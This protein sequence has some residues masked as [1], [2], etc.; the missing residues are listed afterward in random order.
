MTQNEDKKPQDETVLDDLEQILEDS[1]GNQYV[2]QF[3][4]GVLSKAQYGNSVKTQAVYLSQY[5]LIPYDRVRDHFTDQLLIP[6][7][8]GT[9]HN[10]NRR[11][12][13]QLEKF[14]HW[15]KYQLTHSALLH[16][17]ETGININGKRHWLHCASNLEYTYYFPH[18]RRGTEAMDEMGVLPQFT[19]SSACYAMIIGSLTTPT[20]SACMHC[21]TPTTCVNCSAPGSRT[22][23]NG[24]RRCASI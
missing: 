22:G 4:L 3:P 19:S 9:I 1:E 5:Q 13:D 20:C 6:L 7:S 2:A 17:D 16:V 10:F 21:A 12:F 23:R 24:L 15:V 8:A 14:E 18:E 11:A